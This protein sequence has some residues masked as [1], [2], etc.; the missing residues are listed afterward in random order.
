MPTITATN[1]SH[2]CPSNDDLQ[3]LVRD[4]L[5]AHENDEVT[6][7]VGSCSGC[8]SR[9][10]LV[11]T[12]GDVK[13]S[14]SFRSILTAE[15][16]KE[17][18]YWKAI[19]RAENLLDITIGHEQNGSKPRSGEL[20]LDF[21]QPTNTPDRIGRI[22]AFEVVRVVGR[23]GMG[24]VLHAIDASLQRDVAVKVLDPLLA[25]DE[26]ARQRFCREARAAAAVTHDN[27]VAVYQVNEDDRS[28]LPYM[29]MQ[30]VNGETLE[31]RLLRVK[32]LSVAE[33]VNF[34]MQAAAGLASA[35]AAKLIHR[36]IK[37]A[38]IM[39]ESGTDKVVLTDFGLARAAEDMKLTR[40]GFVA[41]TPLYMAPEQ[42]RGDD[43]DHRSDLF[44]LGSVLYESLAGQPPFAGK[45]PLAVLR[46]L[47]DEA[48]IPLHTLNPEVPAWLEDVIDRLLAKDP[49]KRIQSAAELSEILSAQY[50]CMQP[51]E[52]AVKSDV[53]MLSL[54]AAKFRAKR[55]SHQ[56]RLAGLLA[57]PFLLGTVAGAAGF[58]AFG[59][60]RE[61]TV[62]VA[63]PPVA[64]V[65]NAVAAGPT[66]PE[67]TAIYE[68]KSGAVWTVSASKDSNRIAMGME[69]GTVVLWQVNPNKTLET[70][71][72]HSGPVWTVDLSA[73]GNTLVTASDDGKI[74]IWDVSVKAVIKLELDNE[75]SVKSA[76]L[77]AAGNMIVTGDR[78]GNV[79]IWDIRDLTVKKPTKIFKHAGVINGVAF[80]PDDTTIASISSN[81]ETIL[82]EVA[83]GREQV[84]LKGH[85]GPEY[86]VSFSRDEAVGLVATAS[87]DHTVRI[88]KVNNGEF[89]RAI[90]T[91]DEGIWSVAFSCCGRILATAGQ[92][93]LIKLWDVETGEEIERFTRHKGTVH[94][95]R[96]TPDGKSL[97]S[98]GR[99]GTVRIWKIK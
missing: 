30:L 54:T 12:D 16:P 51:A 48:H 50:A 49:N 37:P 9:L 23:G 66:G 5:P 11:A 15:P 62:E 55:R 98:G 19:S 43:V 6:E 64:Q 77:N 29:V 39:I 67:A 78:M 20:K 71:E 36:D 45:T 69:D 3:K 33:A 44:S 53:C 83:T 7:H 81:K 22:G 74:K 88:Y 47:S 2:E 28:G 52:H 58:Y 4:R 46:R 57:V 75:G 21:L 34:G 86:G 93:G 32:K 91:G 76:A 84:K 13:F 82:W 10:E 56:V 31:E 96:F 68:S 59:P 41:G 79:K 60:T 89:V 27:I 26:L 63:G 40:T 87:W 90:N 25:N 42:A 65:A 38:N 97:V 73:D 1:T 94:A 99:D 35:H 85:S 92:D 14:G 95:V 70:I 24:V 61:V 72:A 17:S 8:Q 18:A 80:S